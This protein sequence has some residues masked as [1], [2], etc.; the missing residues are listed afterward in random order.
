MEKSFTPAVE[1]N[2][3][4]LLLGLCQTGRLSHGSGWPAV[5]KG[6]HQLRGM[7][8]VGSAGLLLLRDRQ[9]PAENVRWYRELT[10]PFT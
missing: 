4:H 7:H 3:R 1:T 6:P 8:V 9:R 5:H 10:D 2:Y